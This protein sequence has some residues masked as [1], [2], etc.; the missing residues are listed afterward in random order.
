MKNSMIVSIK[1]SNKLYALTQIVTFAI[2]II[3][4][5]LE[6]RLVPPNFFQY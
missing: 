2:F 5:I 1:R 4:K 3:V 6:R